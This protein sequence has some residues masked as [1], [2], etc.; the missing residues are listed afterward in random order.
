MVDIN[1]KIND[2]KEKIKMISKQ[3]NDSKNT[4][5]KYH[6]YYYIMVIINSTFTLI[7]ILF[8]FYNLW[9]HMIK[10]AFFKNNNAII[11]ISNNNYNETAKQR[12][13]SS[14]NGNVITK[15]S[16]I[17]EGINNKSNIIYEPLDKS[18]NVA[19]PINNLY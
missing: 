4:L 5:K 10:K 18:G 2:L 17:I 9:N 8:I 15:T 11:S 3:N 16:L 14:V 7:I 1:K 19:P 13:K 12:N 6:L